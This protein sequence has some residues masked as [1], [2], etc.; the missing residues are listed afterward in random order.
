MPYS[1]KLSSKRGL[2][3]RHCRGSDCLVCFNSWLN[4]LHCMAKSIKPDKMGK[5]SNRMEQ[6]QQQ[7]ITFF[8]SCQ[9]LPIKG[10]NI[11]IWRAL[12]HHLM[13]N[14]TICAGWMKNGGE[15][16]TVCLPQNEV[17]EV[18]ISLASKKLLEFFPSIEFLHY[19]FCIFLTPEGFFYFRK[20]TLISARWVLTFFNFEIFQYYMKT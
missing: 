13:G 20:F 8:H 3:L 14:R 18:V 4:Y 6:Q 11:H 17:D 16:E 7:F 2:A 10:N 1:K 19:T 9:T 15:R 5:L 12:L